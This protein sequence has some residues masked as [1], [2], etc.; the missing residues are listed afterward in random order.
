MTSLVLANLEDDIAQEH[1]KEL[2]PT[3]VFIDLKKAFD[4]LNYN[5]LGD[6]LKTTGLNMQ[7]ALSW[8]KHY[9]SN[10]S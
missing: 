5:I 6:K 9:P 8:I 4:K 2:K 7:M 10:R 3:A 1:D